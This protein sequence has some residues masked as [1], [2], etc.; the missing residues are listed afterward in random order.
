MPMEGALAVHAAAAPIIAGALAYLHARCCAVTTPL[1]TGLVFVGV[2]AVLDAALIAPFVER[3]WDMFRSPIGTWIPFAL[4]F[5]ASWGAA[6][7]VLGPGAE[8]RW[9]ATR[10]E[11]QRTLPGDALSG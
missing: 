9:H 4:M 6:Q 1:V 11:G 8:W 3:S 5:L 10:E 2:P 7:W